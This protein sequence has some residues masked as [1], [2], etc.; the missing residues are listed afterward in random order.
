MRADDSS[1]DVSGAGDAASSALMS[2]KTDAGPEVLVDD[3][4]QLLEV[5]RL[6]EIV[7]DAG[8]AEA[9][10]LPGR[11]VGREHD[12]RDVNGARIT[13][14]PFE[15]LE[16]VDVGEVHV[17]QDEIRS[18]LLGQFDAQHPPKSDVM[19]LMLGRC[20]KSRSTSCTLATSSSI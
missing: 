8:V 9:A 14:K 12:D 10:S 6:R 5:E 13:L 4:E 3:V 16:S 2:G 1:S 18:I 19:R 15:H 20:M 7:M 17:E 11:G